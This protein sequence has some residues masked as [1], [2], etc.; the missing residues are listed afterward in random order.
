[1]MHSTLVWDCYCFPLSYNSACGIVLAIVM[2]VIIIRRSDGQIWMYHQNLFE[3]VIPS[4][5]IGQNND[6][7][8][9]VCVGSESCA[10]SLLANMCNSVH[11]I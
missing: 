8:L 11:V 9:C 5:D 2:T 4:L 6:M 7:D 10:L 3:I 1:M